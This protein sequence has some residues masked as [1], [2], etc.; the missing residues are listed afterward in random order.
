MCTDHQR[1]AGQRF[2]PTISSIPLTRIVRPARWSRRD[3]FV[4][5]GLGTAGLAVLS[6]CGSDAS[7]TTPVGSA[8]PAQRVTPSPSADESTSSTDPTATDPA[9]SAD[10]VL[11]LEHVSLGFVS[12]YV[13]VRGSEVAVVDTGVSGSGEAIFEAIVGV[14]LTPAD[15]GHIVLTHNHGDHVGSLGELEA[16]APNARAYAGAG[17]VDTIRTSLQLDQ[18]TDGDEV[19]G[20]GIVATP[21]HTPGSISVFD[22][23]TGLLVA[24]DAI[25]GDRAGGIT[26]ANP[27]FTPDMDTARSSIAKLAQLEVRVAAFGHG[28]PPVTEAAK[29]KL[30]ALV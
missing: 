30:G 2:A 14:G 18:V 1:A 7:T 12:A 8:D 23:D 11:R 21:G 28:G 3:V 16:E 15:I 27:D 20:L 4:N 6:A 24:G 13:L 9:A 5:L 29:A 10:D 19:F 17:D 22:T 26:G 25:N